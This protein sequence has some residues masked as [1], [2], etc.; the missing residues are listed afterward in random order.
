[1]S[2]N[3]SVIC[4]LA[5]TLIASSVMANSHIIRSIDFDGDDVFDKI[6][7]KFLNAYQLE[8]GDV[9]SSNNLNRF[10]ADYQRYYVNHGYPTASIACDHQLIDHSVAIQCHLKAG[11]KIETKKVVFEGNHFFSDFELSRVAPLQSSGLLSFLFGT[12]P[13]SKALLDESVRSI[14]QLYYDYGFDKAE[15]KAMVTGDKRKTVVF[16]IVENER[17]RLKSLTVQQQNELPEGLNSDKILSWFSVSGNDLINMGEFRK[18]LNQLNKRIMAEGYD[19]LEFQYDFLPLT[20]ALILKPQFYRA[21][22]IKSL[23]FISSQD[24][25]PP[26]T[27]LSLLSQIAQLKE[28]ELFS[29]K[30]LRQTERR[31]RSLSYIRGVSSRFDENQSDESYDVTFM[32]SEVDEGSLNLGVG[33][34][35]GAEQPQL[36][37]GIDK[38]NFLGS[39]QDLRFNAALSQDTQSVSLRH[40]KPF[41]F[42]DDIVQTLSLDYH[43][44]DSRHVKENNYNLDKRGVSADYLFR[45]DDDWY[46]SLGLSWYDNSITLGSYTG[47]G[48][49]PRI[50]RIQNGLGGNNAGQADFQEYAITFGAKFNT[51]DQTYQPTEGMLWAPSYVQAFDVND[52]SINYFRLESQFD[53]YKSFDWQQTMLTMH[54]KTVLGY[55]DL[56]GG[57]LDVIH[58]FKAGGPNSLRGFYPGS[59]DDNERGDVT[60]GGDYLWTQHIDLSTDV[61]SLGGRV[62]VY[63]DAGL[64]TQNVSRLTDS[65]W[66]R[67][68]VGVEYQYTNS[69]IG[70]I[71]IGFGYPINP[72]DEDKLQ[73]F[74]F[75]FGKI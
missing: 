56:D 30:Q 43:K 54:A 19:N 8:E 74:Y 33:Y 62:A 51:L 37:F 60:V 44:L 42:G 65:A 71:T 24:G 4:S 7:P 64:T 47:G 5:A 29:L 28:G 46:Y 13:F 26:T 70:P 59:I 73:K 22:P 75:K 36:N 58:S 32:F 23:R 45:L 55:G 17:A 2:I 9:F 12:K 1:M 57:S 41:V 34:S 14:M 66:I 15:I 21:L 25:L 68:S 18:S 48:T 27:Q 40:V 10:S 16:S 52:Q 11:D 6:R 67:K 38:S 31:L 53:F 39:G 3:K 63:A 20:K 69:P 49:D 50:D 35:I 61:K 72:R